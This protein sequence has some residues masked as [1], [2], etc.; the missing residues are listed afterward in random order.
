MARNPN[1]M[2]E[3]VAKLAGAFKASASVLV[4][5]TQDA[6]V[7]TGVSATEFRTPYEILDGGVVMTYES[8]DFAIMVADLPGITP[9]SGDKITDANGRNFIVSMPGKMNV[10]E[11]FQG[12]EYKIHSKAVS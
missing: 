12:I 8:H 9:K 10:Y 1:R 4:S 7:I 11:I 5:Y 2:Q 6:E 3:A